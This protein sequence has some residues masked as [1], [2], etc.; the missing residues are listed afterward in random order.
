MPD[1]PPPAPEQV[2]A[3]RARLAQRA[4]SPARRRRPLGGWKG[5]ALAA[6]AVI[7]V[8]GA[9]A[10]LLPPPAPAPVATTPR[11]LLEAAA[12]RLAAQPHTVLRYWR[13][14]T[15]QI[16]RTKGDGGYLV[17]ERSRDVIAFGRDRD[18]YTWHEAVSAEPYDA[19]AA[20]AW[21]RAGSPALPGP[22]LRP[23]P[24]RVRGP[25]DGPPA[26]GGAR[27]DGDAA[28]A[29]RAAQE[30]AALRRELLEHAQDT[31][32]APRR[33]GWRR[34]PAGSSWSSPS[35]RAPRRR[36]IACWPGCPGSACAATSAIRPAAG[37]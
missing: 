19:E 34:P 14:D 27:L 18:W 24:A 26:G 15:E 13:Q 1:V 16:A 33:S 25:L 21:R 12:D 32:G 35:P 11:Q 29:A 23:R 37:R 22:R 10:V 28:G 5:M 36:P 20:E 30:P 7:L 9:V 31:A 6:A 3:V 2:A 8:I 4:A 17:E